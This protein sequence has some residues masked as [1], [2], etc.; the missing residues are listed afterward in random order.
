MARY[1]DSYAIQADGLATHRSQYLGFVRGIALQAAVAHR[2]VELLTAVS[3]SSLRKGQGA[4]ALVNAALAAGNIVSGYW[5]NDPAQAKACPRCTS[6][7]AG[8]LRGLRAQG[9]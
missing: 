1:A 5:L 4:Q 7:A 9:M 3:G 6:A 8:F 2:G